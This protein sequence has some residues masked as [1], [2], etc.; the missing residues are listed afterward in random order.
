MLGGNRQQET[1]TATLCCCSWPHCPHPAQH[2]HSLVI[3]RLDGCNKPLVDLPDN[4]LHCLQ[5]VQYVCARMIL[6]RGKYEHVTPMLRELH[7]FVAH[8]KPHPVQST[9]PHI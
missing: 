4:L 1:T 3:T 8:Q 9:L 6:G 5:G 7:L 2:E